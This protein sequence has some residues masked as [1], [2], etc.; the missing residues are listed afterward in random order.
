MA[1]GEPSKR[2]GLSLIKLKGVVIVVYGEIL[3]EQADNV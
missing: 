3:K 2:S 1:T